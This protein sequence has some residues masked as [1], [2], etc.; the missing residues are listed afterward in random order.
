LDFHGNGRVQNRTHVAP[1]KLLNILG[2]NEQ[3]DDKILKDKKSFK[4]ISS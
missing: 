4:N 2:R 1:S 3:D